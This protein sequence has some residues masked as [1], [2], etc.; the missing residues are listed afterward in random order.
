[1]RATSRAHSREVSTSSAAMRNS[2]G[3]F[4]STDLEN[5]NNL[6]GSAAHRANAG[7][8]AWDAE[9]FAFTNAPEADQYLTKTYRD[10][11][12]IQTDVQQN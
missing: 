7:K 3:F 4:A 11:W 5:L 8:L 2:G 9:A 6:L 12:E 1:M 10:G